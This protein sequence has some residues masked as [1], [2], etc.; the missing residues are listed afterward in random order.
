MNNNS[1]NK[2]YANIIYNETLLII[3]NKNGSSK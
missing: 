2:I 3:N 1:Y